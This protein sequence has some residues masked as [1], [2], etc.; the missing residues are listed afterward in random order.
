[1]PLLK[2]LIRSIPGAVKSYTILKGL[3]I[4]LL[5]Y[6][7]LAKLFALSKI[8]KFEPNDSS[9]LIICLTS[10]PARINSVWITIESILQQEYKPWKIVLVLAETEFPMRSLPKSLIA[11]QQRGI[12]ILWTPRNTRSYK[13]L[14]PVRELYP[15]SYI[16]TFDDDVIYEP[17]RV[18]KLVAA[19]QEFP[20]A[21]IG[22]RGWEISV[23]DDQIEPYTNWKP[24][25][26]S[27]PHNK[28]FLTGVG[29]IFYPPNVLDK[30][31]LLDIDTALRLAPTGDDIWFW[32]VATVS[33]TPIICLGFSK[34][35]LINPNDYQNALST[36]NVTGGKNDEQ[37]DNVVNEYNLKRHII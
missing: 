37:I 17:W 15:H 3:L 6:S 31:L 21:V 4:R 2:N 7:K 12:D 19:S 32:A 18:S 24:A 29:G 14:L 27:T 9:N 33:R 13:K 5:V 16:I 11:Q 28:V 20:D 30:S 23:S 1:M 8:S 35:L 36:L 25:D 22:Y 34:H 26:R 10:F